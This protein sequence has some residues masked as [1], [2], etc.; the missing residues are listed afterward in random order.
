MVMSVGLGGTG[1][2]MFY[3]MTHAFFKALLFLGAG[4]VIHA[5][6]TNSVWEMGR[7]YPK[8]KATAITFILGALAMMGVFP[9]A[10]FW[11]K[12]E[13]LSTAFSSGHWLL[14]GAGTLTAF[15]TGI[16]IT[17]IVILAFFGKKRH[18]GQPH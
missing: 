5:C 7:L 2:G 18:H 3:L 14:Y 1:A 15:I 6:H 17:K 8:M 9:F 16:F 13:I 10:G 11:S 4:S 12:D